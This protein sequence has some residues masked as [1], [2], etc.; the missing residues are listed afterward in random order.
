VRSFRRIALALVL[1]TA[2]SATL[3]ILHPAAAAPG[4]LDTS[5]GSGGTVETP[6][7]TTSHATAL[8]VQPD[9]RIVAGGTSWVRRG[10]SLD[11][12]FTVTR[13]LP[14]GR[15]DA[16][17][18]SGGVATGP[19][20][21]ASALALQPDGKIVQAGLSSRD[22]RPVFALARYRL[23]GSLDGTFGTAGVVIGPEGSARDVA[24]QTDGKVL[25]AGTETNVYALRLVRLN[26][27]GSL[28][29][30]FGTDGIV[31]T[32]LGSKASAEAVVVQ[33]DGKIVAAGVSVPGP[34]PPPPPPP[35]AP[36]PPPPPGPP[37]DAW[38]MTLV[39]Y[40]PDGSL[41]SSF[42]SSGIVK[43]A[44]GYSAT[45][46]DLAIQSDGK[47]VVTG[48]TEER[49]FAPGRVSLARY[50]ADGALDPAFGSGGIAVTEVDRGASGTDLALQPDRKIVVGGTF[51]VARYGADGTLDA[52]FGSG[53]ISQTGPPLLFPPSAVALQPD[54]RIVT[55]GSRSRQGN[56]V[57]ALNRYF[58][59]SVSTMAAVPRS[60]RYGRTALLRGTLADGQAGARVQIL[61]RGCYELRTRVAATATTSAGGRWQARVPLTSRAIF[62]ARIDPETTTTLVVQVRPRITLSKVGAGRF[63]A[64]VFARGS[65]GGRT[66]VLQQFSGRRWVDRQRIVLRRIVKRGRTIVSGRTFSQGNT[67]GRR[68]R[69]AYRV[70]D[71]YACYASAASRPI[72]G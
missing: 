15:L 21:G 44:F 5:F 53:G 71:P 56:A 31:R 22:N 64:R 70:R 46:E 45:V 66:V 17:F 18:G 36:P 35:P 61:R 37:P 63:R 19:C 67:A 38:Q 7:G 58:A 11:S 65:L 13:Y 33:P 28:D 12:S 60:G 29:A 6:I 10:N 3:L 39:R 47:L 42:G 32:L 25:V 8:L 72:T 59:R 51:G 34:P 48:H 9:G 50:R 16:G 20:C 23:D 41:D 43:T 57:F 55:A 54:G 24:V 4:D 26:P 40:E 69:L 30:T 68:L 27:D 62:Q 52:T 14:D 2:T 1:A 49:I